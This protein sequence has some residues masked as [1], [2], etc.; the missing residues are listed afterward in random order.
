MHFDITDLKLFLAISEEGSLTRGAEKTHLSA[1]SASVRIRNLEE[2]INARLLY[3]SSQGVALTPAGE[4]LR[5]HARQ[6]LNQMAV[7]RSDMQEHGKGIK[8]LVR[9]FASITA[10]A[11]YLPPL[12]SRYLAQ[13]SDVDI[14]LREYPSPEIVR[15]VL[16]GK[17]DLG[18]VAGSI[19]TDSLELLPFRT[20]RL[21]LVAPVDHPLAE[22]KSVS[23]AESMAYAQIS[24]PEGTGM[25]EFIRRQAEQ[26]GS[27]LKI[28]IQVG[29]FETFCRMVEAQVGIGVMPFSAASRLGQLHRFAIIDLNDLWSLRRLHLCARRFDRLPGYARQLVTLLMP[30]SQGAGYIPV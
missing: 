11:E 18:I 22:R 12:L 29:N 5:H 27:A 26:A 4:T 10:V 21:V 17:T 25:Y 3:R 6:L 16:E 24:L 15:S 7:M 19:T 9:I 20:D 13:Y 14:D 8:G 23:F 30:P 28:R 1:A 2:S